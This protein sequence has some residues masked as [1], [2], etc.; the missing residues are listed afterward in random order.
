MI[1]FI[2]KTAVEFY[3]PK[4]WKFKFEANNKFQVETTEQKM[5][6]VF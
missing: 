4:D 3:S 5:K 1:K 2:V 6:M